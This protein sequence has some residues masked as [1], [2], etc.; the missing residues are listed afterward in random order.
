MISEQIASFGIVPVVR[1]ERAGDAVP[2]AEAL[3]AGGIRVVEFTFRTEA[4]GEAIRNSVEKLPEMLVGAGTV[5][6]VA[7]FEE[8]MDAGARF[9]VTP[10][11]NRKVVETAVREHVPIYPG[12]VTPGELERVLEYGIKTVKFFPAEASGGT[13][14]LKAFAGPYGDVN[15]IP[16]G[17][18][19]PENFEQY[20]GLG[21]VLAVGGSWL[22][23]G[24][25][26]GRLDYRLIERRAAEAMERVAALR[27]RAE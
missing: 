26:S 13:A 12:I 17:G 18:I 11:F 23:K 27:G 10:G 9:V 21:N 6:S 24:D 15:F 16:T 19:G 25:D 1:I 22:T 4:A 14:T 20:L 2:L 3:W 5:R 8:A 7:Q